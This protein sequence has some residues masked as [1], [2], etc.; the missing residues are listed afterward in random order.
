MFVSPLY[1]HLAYNK[2]SLLCRSCMISILNVSSCSVY[3]TVMKWHKIY[4]CNKSNCFCHTNKIFNAYITMTTPST[5]RVHCIK[6]THLYI[7]FCLFWKLFCSFSHFLSLHLFI[8]F[9]SSPWNEDDDQLF[10]IKSKRCWSA[11]V[12]IKLYVQF[13]IH[14]EFW[15]A[16]RWCLLLGKQLHGECN[17][18]NVR[19]HISCDLI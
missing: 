19:I 10:S 1:T 7:F 2:A 6:H 13:Y 17:S 3:V 8:V 5:V 14:V 16:I 9:C 11:Y 18:C 15:L 12:F 4:H